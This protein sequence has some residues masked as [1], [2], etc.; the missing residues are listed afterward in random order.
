MFAQKMETPPIEAPI[1][2]RGDAV[3][4]PDG[5]KGVVVVAKKL[6]GRRGEEGRNLTIGKGYMYRESN[7]EIGRAA[8]RAAV[9]V[10]AFKPRDRWAAWRKTWVR[11]VAN[12][13]KRV[14]GGKKKKKN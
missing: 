7:W 5:S 9:R 2:I 10:K 11:K 4:N 14:V 8:E 1:E 13:E 12:R 3:L 6:K